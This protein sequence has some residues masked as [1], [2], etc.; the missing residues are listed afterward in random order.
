MRKLISLQLEA[1]QLQLNHDIKYLK[2]SRRLQEKIIKQQT[3]M[4]QQQQRAKL[5]DLTLVSRLNR[6]TH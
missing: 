2:E 5:K 4:Q 3:K 6:Q 1:N